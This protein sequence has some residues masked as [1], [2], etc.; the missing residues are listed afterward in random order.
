MN[1]PMLEFI[2]LW[3]RTLLPSALIIKYGGA[4]ILTLLF[5]RIE[6]KLAIYIILFYLD[7]H[8]SESFLGLFKKC[9]ERKLT[10]LILSIYSP[11]KKRD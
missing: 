1:S 9:K 7:G 11:L 2:S 4:N 6:R 10:K 5:F 3:A 8:I